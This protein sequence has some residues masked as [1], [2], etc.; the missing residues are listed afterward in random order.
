MSLPTCNFYCE[1]LYKFFLE[2][3]VRSMQEKRDLL[4]YLN[5]TVLPSH[6][7]SVDAKSMADLI[8]N[9]PCFL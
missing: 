7:L 4:S 8:N 1:F 3:G 9:N 6:F 2:L 5:L